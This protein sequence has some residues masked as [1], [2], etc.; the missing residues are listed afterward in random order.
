[1]S[2]EGSLKLHWGGSGGIIKVEAQAEQMVKRSLRRCHFSPGPSHQR[3]RDAKYLR[4]TT[5]Q[6]VCHQGAQDAAFNTRMF[7]L[8]EAGGG[9]T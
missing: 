9:S 6:H 7:L 3:P 8:K 1:M 2:I 5:S 4:T